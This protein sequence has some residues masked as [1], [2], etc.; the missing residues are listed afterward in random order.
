MSYNSQ[1]LYIYRVFENSSTKKKIKYLGQ[2]LIKSNNCFLHERE[3][4][5]VLFWFQVNKM[6]HSLES[7]IQIVILMAKYEF[8]VMV[9]R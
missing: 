7:K 9:I 5:E 3:M 8:L 4:F 2:F 1:L 6:S